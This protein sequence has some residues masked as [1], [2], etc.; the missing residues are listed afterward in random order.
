MEE[1][2]LKKNLQYKIDFVSLGTYSIVV[3]E[4]LMLTLRKH[5]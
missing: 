4:K 2:R 3:L 1:I 5:L